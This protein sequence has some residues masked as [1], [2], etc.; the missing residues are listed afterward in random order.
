MV[1]GR[2]TAR[3]AYLSLR[4]VSGELLVDRRWGTETSRVADLGGVDAPG[5]VRYEPSGYLDLRRV[6]RHRDV[7]PQDVFLDLGCGKGRIVLQAARYE[8]GRVIG[9]EVSPELCEVARANVR[10]RRDHL[11]SDVELIVADA[12]TFDIPDDVT[13]IYLYNP[14]RG[15]VFAAAV[16]QIVS[17]LNRAPRRVR[18]IYRTPLEEDVLLGTGRFRLTRSVPGLRPTRAW[19]Q[20]MSTRIYVAEPA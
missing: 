3:D 12:A 15:A 20:K 4:R 6:L 2:A 11:R 7:T 19:A 8:F 17:S 16:D 18:V 5:R 10:A 1:N 14:F 13:V 9:V